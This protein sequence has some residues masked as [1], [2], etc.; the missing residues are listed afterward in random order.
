MRLYAKDLLGKTITEKNIDKTWNPETGS[1]P[2]QKN[3]KV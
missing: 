3:I 2:D 1:S